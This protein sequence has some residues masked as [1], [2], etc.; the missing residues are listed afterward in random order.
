MHHHMVTVQEQ[1]KKLVCFSAWSAFAT[2][3][4]IALQLDILN[5]FM[6]AC[7]TESRSS[8][9]AVSMMR[10]NIVSS[11]CIIRKENADWSLI[12][13]YAMNRC[14]AFQHHWLLTSGASIYIQVLDLLVLVAI[15]GSLIMCEN[16]EQKVMLL[17]LLFAPLFICMYNVINSTYSLIVCSYS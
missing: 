9:S 5:Q 7:Y 1:H 11:K 12:Y 6:M 15:T 17:A 2:H 14:F 3:Y 13:N 4:K 16:L 10:K 8:S